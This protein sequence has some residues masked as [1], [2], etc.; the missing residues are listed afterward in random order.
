VIAGA[1][2][3]FSGLMNIIYAAIVRMTRRKFATVNDLE[4][5][6]NCRNSQV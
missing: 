4:D 5:A 2:M 6:K 1:I 3:G